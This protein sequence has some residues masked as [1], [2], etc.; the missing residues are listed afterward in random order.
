M[1]G[2]SLK[3][4][5]EEGVRKEGKN[6]PLRTGRRGKKGEEQEI[7]CDGGDLGRIPVRDHKKRPLH[8]L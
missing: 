3:V 5:L 7:R 6:L 2:D 8:S 4:S 1:P